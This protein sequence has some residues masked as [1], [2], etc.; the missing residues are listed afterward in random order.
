MSED[1]L[2]TRKLKIHIL[3]PVHVGCGQDYAPYEYLA[4]V[5]DVVTFT[6]EQ[7]MQIIPAA[8]RYKLVQ[9]GSANNPVE[10]VKQVIGG[11]KEKLLNLQGIRRVPNLATL[12]S[13]VR[14]KHIERS[15]F[16]PYT[17]VAVLPGSSIK[18]ALRT[19]WIETNP[20]LQT[21]DIP[22]DPLRLLSITD[23]PGTKEARAIVF[24]KR[25]H[26]DPH[27]NPG[28]D[29]SVR[30]DYLLE[31]IQRGGRFDA[32]LTLRYPH[33]RA[34]VQGAIPSL[35][36]LVASANQH[37]GKELQ[38]CRAY[39]SQMSG[40]SYAADWL[41]WIASE[42]DNDTKKHPVD[43]QKKVYTYGGLMQKNKGFLLRIG[44]HG[45]AES[46]TLDGRRKI[47]TK[48]HKEGTDRTLTMTLMANDSNKPQAAEPFGWVFVQIAA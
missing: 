2:S 14:I 17:G 33:Q 10:A 1:F 22:S 15:F 5:Q 18:G 16:N 4:D 23:A 21:I 28:S 3:S 27:R 6:V 12:P 41:K 13:N 26:K 19:A 48:Y 46:L 25:V 20:D 24:L 7:L 45:G 36:D 29:S 11:Y 8:E 31:S 32:E 42:F 9:A 37:Y 40:F 34:T 44:K 30:Y 39:L 47:R 43:P 35:N 38:S